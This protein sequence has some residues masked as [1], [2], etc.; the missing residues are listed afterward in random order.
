GR[1]RKD[2][3]LFYLPEQQ[4]AT[5][6]HR[7]YGAP[8]PTPEQIRQDPAHPWQA[9]QVHA[10]GADHTCRMK[11]VDPVLWRPAGA[12]VLRL[13]V[14]APLAYRP[15]KG[16][17]IRYRDPAFLLC[18]DPSLPPEQIVQ[19]YF[20]RWD[21]EVAGSRF[22]LVIYCWTTRNQSRPSHRRSVA[23]RPFSIQSPSARPLG[24]VPI[25]GCRFPDRTR[26][27]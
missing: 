11:V 5:G 6:R 24:A 8:A 25:L 27:T 7:C 2:A 12:R 14:I 18:T 10:A 19:Q 15:R 3:K 4:P 23:D 9:I 22:Q 17:R 20:R 26:M 16:S 21:I 1:V 13:V